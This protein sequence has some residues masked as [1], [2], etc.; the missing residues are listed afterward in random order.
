MNSRNADGPGV[1]TPEPVTTK[2]AETAKSRDQDQGSAVPT[3]M[4]A[5]AVV[6]LAG[7]TAV[8]DR[9]MVRVCPVEG[10]SYSHLHLVPVGAWREP[11]FRAPRCRPSLR[12]RIE[13]VD[14]LPAVPALAGQRR[15]WT[16]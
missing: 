15:R 5:H 3:A 8:F 16:A 4:V 9:L 2:I 10:C 1:T 12:Y 6:L 14:V 11:L 13:I 7:P